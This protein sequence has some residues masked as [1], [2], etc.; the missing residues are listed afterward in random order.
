MSPHRKGT[1]M[2]RQFRVVNFLIGKRAL[3]HLS[4]CLNHIKI[5]FGTCRYID[6]EDFIKNARMTLIPNIGTI[7]NHEGYDEED[8]T[9]NILDVDEAGR[10][11]T[12][13]FY[14]LRLEAQLKEAKIHFGGFFPNL[15]YLKR[16]DRMIEMYGT[17]SS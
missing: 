10:K 6:P 5:I 12:E 13:Y 16:M 3:P 4:S 7:R 8:V 2:P 1:F 11:F 9:R 15:P 17:L 14:L